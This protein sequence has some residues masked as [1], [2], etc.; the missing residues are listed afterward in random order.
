MHL[1][2]LKHW[3]HGF[4]LCLGLWAYA[5]ALWAQNQPIKLLILGDSLSA[6]YGL[7]TQQGWVSLWQ[8]SD[9]HIRIIN[10]SISGETT[11]GGAA[12]LPALLTQ[13][14]PD[15]LII[16]LGANDALRGQDLRLSEQK[17]RNMI[18]LAKKQG[19]QVAL[20]GIRLP[21]NYGA[22]YS[23][24]LETLYQ[25]LA[26]SEQIPLEPFFLADVALDT[27]LMQADGLHPNEAAQPIILQRIKRWF[28]PL[29]SAQ[30]SLQP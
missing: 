16:E 27:N 24:R 15:W 19:V 21:L 13:H 3:R 7:S 12:R 9:A 11:M 6:A 18:Q 28:Y 1:R 20:L 17:L 10:A 5:N 25:Q 8:A 23:Q 4:I 2:Q 22:L 26:K 30:S 14:Q 29:L